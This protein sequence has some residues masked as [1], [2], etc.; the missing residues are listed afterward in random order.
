[1]KRNFE[2][3]GGQILEMTAAQGAEIYEDSCALLLPTKEAEKPS[4]L[5][6][7]LLIDCMGNASPIVRQVLSLRN[8]PKREPAPCHVRVLLPSKHREM[9]GK[10]LPTN[11]SAM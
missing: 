8:Q 1:M 9:L 6:G 3:A 5:V 10:L 7:R 11:C 4:R 2:L